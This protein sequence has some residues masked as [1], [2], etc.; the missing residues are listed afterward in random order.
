M[1]KLGRA[2]VFKVRRVYGFSIVGGG[3]GRWGFAWC[4][5]FLS[6]EIGKRDGDWEG[7]ERR[8]GLDRVCL[9]WLS[10]IEGGWALMLGR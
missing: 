4:L 9:R 5:C 6:G 10:G 3:K 7:G 2:W 1:E 8:L